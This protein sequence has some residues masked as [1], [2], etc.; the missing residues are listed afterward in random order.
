[1]PLPCQNLKK[2]ANGQSFQNSHLKH[3]P[4]NVQVRMHHLEHNLH[5]FS[6]FI[7]LSLKY[8]I[9]FVKCPY[10]ARIKKKMQT[11]KAFKI[12]VKNTSQENV[13]VRMHNLDHILHLFSK[14]MEL[15]LKSSIAFGKCPYPAIIKN[16]MQTDKAFKIHISNTSQKMYKLGCTTLSIIYTYFQSS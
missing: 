12:H 7:E 5:L 10:P 2:N 13:Q 6:K 9:A 15:S 4:K 1:M 16:K 11:D 3:L 14:F 8:S